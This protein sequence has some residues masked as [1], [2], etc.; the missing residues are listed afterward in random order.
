MAWDDRP[1][2]WRGLRAL[3][4][5]SLLFLL[6]ACTTPIDGGKGVP[7][8]YERVEIPVEKGGGT[9]FHLWPLFSRTVTPDRTETRVLWPLG[10]DKITD[11]QRRSWVIPI[12]SRWRF[13]HPDGTSDV[14]SLLLPAFWGRDAIEGKYFSVFPVGGT[15]KGILGLDRI[16]YALFPLWVRTRDRDRVSNY[17]LWPIFHWSTGTLQRGGR[18]FPFYTR[19]QGFTPEGKPRYDRRAYLWPLIIRQE[20]NLETRFPTKV[21]W[22]W[23]FYG[24]ISSE[25]MRRTSIAWPLIGR[26]LTFEI[27]QETGEAQR[28]RSSWYLFPLLRFSWKK[29]ELVQYDV[30]PLYGHRKSGDTVRDFFLWPLFGR[31]TTIRGD[32]DRRDRWFFPFYRN[33][34]TRTRDHP[35]SRKL[36]RVWPLFRYTRSVDGVR[37]WDVL[38]PLPYYDS[39]GVEWFYSRIWRVYRAV[40]DPNQGRRAWELLWGVA[41]GS[42]DQTG[43][44]FSILGGLFGRQRKSG[45]NGESDTRWRLLYIP[46]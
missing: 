9:E 3:P 19:Y 43:S 22:F 29:E 27:D 46:F 23:P 11:R 2:G 39:P 5:C 7:P 16:D 35:G 12:Y 8:F 40:D 25:R 45:E 15:A 18:V 10:R 6:P 31:E 14:Q 20:N 26:D 24:E 42:R 30:Y 41:S 37:T 4:L 32:Y 1:R 38:D 34:V 36:E 21:R 17:F 28:D 33:V 13:D 44:R